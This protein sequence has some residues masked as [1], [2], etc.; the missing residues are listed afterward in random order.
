M[1]IKFTEYKGLNLPTVASEVLDFWK[2]ENIFEKSVSTREGNPPFVFFEGPPSANGLPGIHH[3]MAR[4][5]K[6]IFCRYK[7]QKGFQVKRKAGWDTHGLPVELGTEAALGITKED[8]GKTISVAEYNEACKKTVMRYTDVWNDLTE[9]MGY[10]VDMEDPYITYKSKYMETVWWI[11]KQIYNK[12]LMYK[13]YTIQPYSPKAG[14]GLSSHEVNQP[15]SYRDVTDTTVVAQFKALNETLPSFLVGFG[16]VHILAW[17]TTPWTLPSNTALTVGPKIDY[18]LV[19]T[20]N[21]YTFLPTS[22]ILAKN[23]VGKQFSK[24][25]FASTEVA[26]FENFKAGDKK[27][28]FQIIAECKGNDLVGIRYEQLLPFTLPYQNPENAFRV[29]SGDF[30]TTE[31]GTGIVHTAPTFGA[32][33]AKVA[34]EAIPEVPPMLVLDENG[35][36]VP[37]VNLQGKFIDGVGSYSGKY[38]KNEY[39]TEGEAPERSMDVE[40]AIQLKEE[41]K[42]F[43]VEKYVHSYPHCWRTDTPILYYPLDSWFIEITKVRD[44]MFE[45]NETINWKPKATGEGRFG[46]WLKNANDWNLSRSRFWGIPLPIWRNE[47]GTEE[48]LIG[49]VEELYNEIEKAIAAGVQKENPFKDFEIGNMDEANYDLV[50]LHK[51]VVDEITLVSVSGKPMK[52]EADLIDVWFDS[53]AMPYAQWHYPFEN[54]DKI[55]GNKDYPA[56]F[57]AEGVDQT[58]GWFYTLHAISTLVF[59]KVAYKN[60]VSNGLVLDKNGQKM[61]KRLGNAADPFDTLNE[62]GPDAT[63]W[64]MISNAN[65]WDNLKFD[66][67]GIAEVR[68]KFFGTLYNTYSFFALY[69]NIDNFTFA[70]AE[71]PMNERPEIDKWI[72]SEL[73]TLVKVVDDAYADYEPTKAARAI[74]EFVQE[75]LS[76][77][78]VR[79]CR[80]RFWKGEY[81]QDKIAAYQTLYTCLL[82]ISKLGAPIAPFFMDKLYR[83]LTLAT[84][85]EKYESVHLAKFP[86]SVDNFVDKSLESK[87]QKAQTVSSLVLSLRKKEM[88][89]VRQPLQKVMIPV[90]DAVFRAE[91]EAVADLIKAEVNVKEITLLDDASGVLVK[92]IKPNF[93]ALGP[94]FGKDMGL[95]A[96]EIQ[97]FSADQI[98]KLDKE[99]S[100]GIVIAGNSIILS[101]EDVEIS[102]QDIEGWLVANSNGITVA[103]DITISPE[104]KQEGI[105]RELVNRIQNIRKDSGFEVTDKIKV[106]LQKNFELENAVKANENYIKSETLTETLVFEEEISEGI[107]IEF[108]EIKTKI[109]ITK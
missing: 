47:E 59:D 108:D 28:P 4:A 37:L 10:W 74:S 5:I 68:R 76:N 57:I 85:T 56:D 33:D 79:L 89:K 16:D 29:I 66:L 83:D 22:V 50:D 17:T 70:E 15:G 78:Y 25:F 24:G 101:I 42:A 73:N 90:L 49:S 14:T 61:S 20:F 71:V 95:I 94:R 58:R 86:V 46:N 19:K 82:T 80:R 2:K 100:I 51:N 99:G 31:D 27:I 32:D 63:R 107:E 60:V 67:E 21:Q 26:D 88:I 8:I 84:H 64:Y 72:I 43:K 48:I 93:K 9:K 35:N 11:L 105:A 1:S 96:K 98:N 91:I 6:D 55:D 109:A 75:N 36:P 102:S 106:H 40:I 92:Q 45:L 12:D 23:L 62:Y 34:K 53:G 103:L 44:R 77:W 87:M 3:V 54:K 41:N 7:T 38:V 13:G 81:A 39:Y 65:P 30:V 104:L 69:A 52:R 97:G 18:V